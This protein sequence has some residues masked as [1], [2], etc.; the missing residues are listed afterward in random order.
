MAHHVRHFVSFGLIIKPLDEFHALPFLAKVVAV[1]AVIFSITV[2]E[3]QSVVI[4]W[5][6]AV[7]VENSAD[8][9]AV[10]KKQN[11]ESHA[12]ENQRANQK[13]ESR[14]FHGDSIASPAMSP[15]ESMS[16]AENKRRRNRINPDFMASAPIRHDARGRGNNMP[17]LTLMLAP[18]KVIT[19]WRGDLRGCLAITVIRVVSGCNLFG[20]FSIRIVASSIPAS[21]CD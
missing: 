18:A 7:T 5:N 15:Q 19:G 9:A 17:E 16:C 14:S 3:K 13:F 2:E 12:Q 20:G 11:G 10:P 1:L 8:P 21:D 6:V 4:N